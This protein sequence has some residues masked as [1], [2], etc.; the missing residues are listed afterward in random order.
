[1]DACFVLHCHT[2]REKVLA[3]RDVTID[4]M[5]WL[6]FL[7]RHIENSAAKN[8]SIVTE[9]EHMGIYSF[10]DLKTL[11][12]QLGYSREVGLTDSSYRRHRSFCG[13]AVA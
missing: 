12:R 13:R 6:F 9:G 10:P 8:A 11:L 1:M 4:Q 2:E 5:R 3:L 7:S